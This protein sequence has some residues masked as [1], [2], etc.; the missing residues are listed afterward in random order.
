[1]TAR[2]SAMGLSESARA[3]KNAWSTYADEVSAEVVTLQE[4]PIR[5]WSDLTR[6]AKPPPGSLAFKKSFRQAELAC[7]RHRWA[8]HKYPGVVGVAV[9]LKITG[10]EV[11]SIPCV[12]VY[13]RKKGL[14]SDINAVPRTVD[15][16]PTDVIEAGVPSF[17]AYS[18]RVRPIKPGYSISH[19][20]SGTGTL[21]CFVRDRKTGEE[22]LLSNNHVIANSNLASKGDPVL[23][24]GTA[25]HGQNPSDQVAKLVRFGKVNPGPN[26]VDAA[27]AKPLVRHDA[28]IPGIGLPN[29]VSMSSPFGQR[30]LKA[31]SATEITE[32]HVIA[33]DGSIGPMNF[34]GI[35]GVMFVG[36]VVTTG[37][38]QAGDSGSL[39]LT[40]YER[41]AVGLLFAGLGD[42]K[43][44]PDEVATYHN[45]IGN[46][47]DKLKVELVTS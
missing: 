7:K 33:F 38:S 6:V 8:L 41:L 29:G 14:R 34:G 31:G 28:R 11:I 42:P 45:P 23:Q 47:L 30:V 1:M 12:T 10:N 43:G 32:G 19:P 24:P 15:K 20:R 17:R 26:R 39:L 36:Q 2:Q 44:G 18:G 4:R 37:M 9:S 35:G 16:V 46:V 5:R 3:Y 22:L 21:G 40:K 13:V 25:N 27:V